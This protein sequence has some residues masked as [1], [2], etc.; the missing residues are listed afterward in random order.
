[1]SNVSLRDSLVADIATKEISPGRGPVLASNVP[2]F[3]LL[4][5][6]DPTIGTLELTINQRAE[7]VKAIKRVVRRMK[8]I[9]YLTLARLYFTKFTLGCRSAVLKL[10][11]SLWRRLS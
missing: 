4:P 3:G 9:L 8:F 1:M 6:I 11:R 5:A 2:H 7:G 10:R